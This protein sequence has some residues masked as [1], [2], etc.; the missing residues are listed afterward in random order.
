M[1]PNTKYVGYIIEH[2]DDDDDDCYDENNQYRSIV[3]ICEKDKHIYSH[4]YRRWKQNVK[5]P[6][7]RNFGE[8]DRQ[9]CDPQEVYDIINNFCENMIENEGI[10]DGI[11][12]SLDDVDK[13][14][15]ILNNAYIYH[16]M[17][18]QNQ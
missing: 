17:T 7:K 1:F 12:M 3:I 13:L 2:D 11:F 14:S 4:L 6:I 10:V 9:D 15:E 5:D 16:F 8:Y 18:L